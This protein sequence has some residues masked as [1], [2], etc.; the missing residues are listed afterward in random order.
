MPQ[1]HLNLV[2]YEKLTKIKLIAKPVKTRLDIKKMP[3]FKIL[4][5]NESRLNLMSKINYNKILCEKKN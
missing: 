2:W 3:K 5:K 4:V 1:I